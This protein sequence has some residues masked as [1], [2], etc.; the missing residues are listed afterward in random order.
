MSKKDIVTEQNEKKTMTK[1][2][3]KMQKRK[4]AQAKAKKQALKDKI[5]FSVI[6]VAL[7][8]FIAYFPIRSFMAVNESFV[9]VKGEDISRVEFDYNYNV[10]KNNYLNTYG[11][12]LTA[13]GMDLSGDLSTMMFSETLTWEDYFEKEAMGSIIRGKALKDQAEAAGFTYDVE[14]DYEEYKQ[15]IIEQAEALGVTTKSYI[16]QAYG[17][18]ATMSRIE[19]YVKESLYVNAYY[20]QIEEEKAPS[21]DEIQAYYEADKS[22]F[23][24]VDYYL[25]I[26]N[27]DIPT[28]PTELADPVDE[29]AEA[30]TDGTEPVEEEYQPSEAEIEK[31]MADAKVLAEAAV[32]IVTT[33]GELNENISYADAPSLCRDWLFDE[34]R[35]EGDT[36]V[37]E[38]TASNAYYVLSFVNR[39]L[40]ETLTVDARIIMTADGNGQDILDEWKNGEATE[41]SFAALADKY[42]E[43]TSFTS[44]GGF[45]EGI[46][47]SGTQEAIAAWMFDASRTAGETTAITTE[48]GSTYVLYYVGTNE[49]EWKMTAKAEILTETIEA[50]LQEISADYDIEDTKG[51]LEYLVIEAAEEAASTEATDAAATEATE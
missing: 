16:Q 27:A 40:D 49:A 47:P 21:D 17:S 3:Q 6:I 30:A 32:E 50:Y 1:Y 18:Y 8:C 5:I 46:S 24:S 19:D 28:E 37:I 51:N 12:Y 9:K 13:F 41:E 2:D 36:T 33:D 20:T 35:K 25:T 10:I 26:I 39:Y 14:E 11:S 38:Y 22:A 15:G 34:S 23:D 4:E 29:T 31:A 48:D 45:Y 43:G 42:N 44:E 7:I